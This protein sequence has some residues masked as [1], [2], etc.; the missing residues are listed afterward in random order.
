M[1]SK[2]FV[3]LNCIDNFAKVRCR[4]FW[5]IFVLLNYIGI[6]Y[7]PHEKLLG[8]Q[9]VSIPSTKNQQISTPAHSKG[10]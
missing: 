8:I 2:V 1:F 5:Q 6:S 3:L 9:R 4:D 7:K 10:Y